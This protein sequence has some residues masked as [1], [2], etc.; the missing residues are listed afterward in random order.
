MTVLKYV[1]KFER[2]SRYAPKL[3]DM[4]EK[5]IIKFLEGLNPILEQHATGV[6]LPA[7]FQKAVKRAY[8]FEDIH[9]KI[10][11]ED[12]RKRQQASS[13]QQQKEKPRQDQNGQVQGQCEHCGRDHNSNECRK[14][15]GACFKCGSFDHLLRNCPRLN[16]QGNRPPQQ[17]QQAPPQNQQALQNQARQPQQQQQVRQPPQNQNRPLQQNKNGQQGRQNQ[18]QNRPR[19]QGR[20]YYLNQVDA[21]T[22]GNVVEGKLLVCGIEAKILFDPGSTHSFISHM[23]V[24]LIATPISEL[25]FV[26]VVTTPVGK[27]TICRNYYP[28]C[29]VMV[30]EVVDTKNVTLP[31]QHQKLHGAASYYKQANPLQ[32]SNLVRIK[33][34]LQDPS[35]QPKKGYT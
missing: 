28:N 19:Q 4:K 1:T 22:A 24:K 33:Q 20:A 29:S 3:V 5:K 27:Q 21:D 2:L 9:K 16:D 10:I 11:Q 17:Q 14:V 31:P 12:Q 15:T 7:T 23:F 30:G 35:K 13:R 18:G 34:K 26:L 32:A 6:V 25:A 8:K